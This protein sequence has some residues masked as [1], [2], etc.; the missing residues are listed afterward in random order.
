M[1]LPPPPPPGWGWGWGWDDDPFWDMAAGAAIAGTTAAI[2]SSASQPD[3]VV[4]NA[5]PA[6]VGTVVYSL[7]SGCGK[8]IRSSLTYY[9]CNNVWY[10]PQYLSSG[11]TYQIVA[12]PP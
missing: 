10:Q 8:V 9:S 12:P 1:P 2:V 5:G 3:V 4:V 11:V 6:T 7:P